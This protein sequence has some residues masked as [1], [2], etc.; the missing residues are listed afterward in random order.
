M[1]LPTTSQNSNSS[2][3]FIPAT[4]TLQPDVDIDPSELMTWGVIQGTP[5][6]VGD[7]SVF[8]IPETPRRD[9]LAGKLGGEAGNALKMRAAGVAIKGA[10]SKSSGG[11]KERMMPPAALKL[12]RRLGLVEI[13]NFVQVIARKFR[14]NAR[15]CLFQHLEL[16]W[17]W[18]MLQVDSCL[19]FFPF[20]FSTSCSTISCNLNIRTP[21]II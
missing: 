2:Y 5:V 4:P 18:R 1:D 10:Q 20:G 15:I 19:F 13:Y 8:R 12:F 14:K 3:S 6:S 7:A 9:V 16:T 21:Q 11:L 17:S